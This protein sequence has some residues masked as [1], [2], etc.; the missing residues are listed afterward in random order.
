MKIMIIKYISIS[1]REK[2]NYEYIGL[3]WKW[4]FRE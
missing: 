2:E 3:R 4:V 1:D